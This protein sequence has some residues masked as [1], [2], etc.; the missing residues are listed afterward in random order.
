MPEVSLVAILDADREGYLRS[1]SSLIQTIG[2]AA[3]NVRGRAILYADRIT[4]SME[5]AMAETERRRTK[6]VQYNEE[7]D[8]TPKTIQKRVADIMEGAYD[9]GKRR[10]RRTARV[11][12]GAG[13]YADV[14]PENLGQAIAELEKEMFRH[15]ELL[16]FEEA[17]RVRDQIGKLKDRVLR[18]PGVPV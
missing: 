17:A 7:H 5:R 3:R 9:D 15:A 6:Q 12:D 1:E 2:R 16:E 11:A 10:G 8:I 14:T 18:K 13:K 4:G